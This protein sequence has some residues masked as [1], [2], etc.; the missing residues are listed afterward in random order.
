MRRVAER[1]IRRPQCHRDEYGYGDIT[2]TPLIGLAK[3]HCREKRKKQDYDETAEK[4]AL[5]V[6]RQ[7]D[8]ESRRRNAINGHNS[9]RPANQ[10]PPLRRARTITAITRPGCALNSRSTSVANS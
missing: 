1:D 4:P 6:N 3:P 2:R 8:S 10:T 7:V 5:D 9:R